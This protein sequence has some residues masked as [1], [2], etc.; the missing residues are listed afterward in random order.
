MTNSPLFKQLPDNYLQCLCCSHYCQIAPGKLGKC[1]IRGNNNG[2]PVL[3]T[4]GRYTV[5]IDPIEKK[6]LH[7][8]LPGSSIYSYGTVGCNFSCQFCQ[9]SSLSMWGLDI[10]DVG[11]IHESDI[12]RLKKL[13]P[14]R[15]V[16]SAIKNSCQSIAS[17]YNEPT[18]SSEF[19]HEVFK[20]AK[21]KGLY[22]V[23][24]TNGYESVECLDY[25]APYLDAVNIDL[26]SFNDKFYMKTCGGHLEPVCNTI[27]RCYAMGIHTEVTTL[28]IPKNND[29]DEELTAAANFLA[30]VGKD[31]PWHLSAYHDD[32]NFEGFGRTPLETLKRAAAIGKKAGLKY[33]YMGNVQAPEARVTRCPNC[34][35]LL[36]DRI[37]FGTEVKM[38]GGKCEKCGEVVPGF[39]SDA[40]NLKPK[41]TRVPDHLRNL[42]NSPV[43]A[44]IES[45]LPQKFVIYATQGGTSQE[46]AEKIA[47]QFGVDA[48]NIA[49]IDPNSLSSADEIVFVLSTYGRGNP[50]QPATKFWETLKST[51][52]DMKNVKFTVLGCGSSGYKKTFC[53]FAKSVFERMKELGAQ[54]LAPLC[55]R[56]ELDDDETY[57]EVTKWIDALKL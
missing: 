24:V 56:D 4:Y 32:Y 54:E 14:E 48:F 37:W 15:V 53:G 16:S 42:S 7:H 39:F 1:R 41:L 29:S 36:V 22:T 28:I 44:K 49:D 8:F 52:I 12:G 21:E 5:A 30:S 18:V 40:N 2:Q 45:K 34:G 25:L 6:P 46:Y 35:H 19:S 9:N 27:R 51:D 13:T 17:T 38:K 20:L 26:K 23:Y 43:T 57:P 11:C 50:P 31:I 10:E 55:T 47:M 33:V 3:P